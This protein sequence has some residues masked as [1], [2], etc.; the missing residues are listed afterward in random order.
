MKN[1]ALEILTKRGVFTR[2]D[3]G[4]LLKKD[5]VKI[6]Y[7]QQCLQYEALIYEMSEYCGSIERRGYDYDENLWKDYRT[8]AFSLNGGFSN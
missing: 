6:N 5:G 2:S 8:A 7:Q 4:A 1:K 3:Y